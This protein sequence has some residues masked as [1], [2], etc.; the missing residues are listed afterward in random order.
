MVDGRIM[1]RNAILL[2]LSL[3]FAV[4][5]ILPLAADQESRDMV[6]RMNV[7]PPT[8]SETRE[9]FGSYY[10]AAFAPDVRVRLIASGLAGDNFAVA[11]EKAGAGYRV[12]SIPTYFPNKEGAALMPARPCFAAMD[13]S[14]A[15]RIASVWKIFLERRQAAS[16]DK[17]GL[18]TK[19][20]FFTADNDSGELFGYA[21]VPGEDSDTNRLVE[22]GKSLTRYCRY[23]PLNWWVGR[24]LDR[25]MNEL[26]ARL[27]H[28]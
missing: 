7:R 19:A 4:S 23:A 24:R 3:V 18:E 25:Q 10:S 12:L 1:K 27:D 28:S 17:G 11:I 16:D 9:R 2:A 22:I 14:R 5:G 6:A 8:A 21:N 26:F 15:E 20:Y 13:R